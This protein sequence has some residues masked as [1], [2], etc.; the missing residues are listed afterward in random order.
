[1]SSPAADTAAAATA[2]A[3]KPSP[4]NVASAKNFEPS[5]PP[6]EGQGPTSSPSTDV[7]DRQ[8]HA[9][10]ISVESNASESDKRH[11]DGSH[12]AEDAAMSQQ[13]SPP[14]QASDPALRR[15]IVDLSDPV[16]AP[17]REIPPQKEQEQAKKKSYADLLKG[18]QDNAPPKRVKTVVN[19][20][21]PEYLSKLIDLASQED[22]NEEDVL[23]AISQATP[24]Q[25]KK[26]TT[27][28]WIETNGALYDKVY[29]NEKIIDAIFKE[30]QNAAWS[31]L[32]LEFVQLNKT[33]IG[34][35][36][37]SVTSRHVK[38]MLVGKTISIFGKEFT[39]PVPKVRSLGSSPSQELNDPMDK[40]F[41]M[42]IVGIRFNF[43]SAK[44]FRLLRRLKMKPIFQ[45]YRQHIPN[46]SCQSNVWRVYFLEAE[47]PKQ[48]VVNGHPADR[49][50]MDGVAYNV[51]V[52]NF[53]RSASRTSSA[54]PH[55]LDLDHAAALM[56]NPEKKLPEPEGQ[57]AED[58]GATQ[59]K[60]AKV[61]EEKQHEEPIVQGQSEESQTIEVIPPLTEQKSNEEPLPQGGDEES[62]EMEVTPLEI[63]PIVPPA[64]SQLSSNMEVDPKSTKRTTSQSVDEDGFVVPRSK[65][66][67][68]AAQA[69]PTFVSWASDNFFNA[70]ATIEATTTPVDSQH[71]TPTRVYIPAIKKISEESLKAR[72]AFVKR[73]HVADNKLCWHPDN[74]TMEELVQV[75]QAS[76]E[77]GAAFQHHNQ[78]NTTDIAG[79]ELDVVDYIRRCNV[80]GLWKVV[81]SHTQSMNV[82]LTKLATHTYS[83][84]LKVVRM[85]AWQRWM[86]A[87]QLPVVDSFTNGFKFTFQEHPKWTR[88]EEISRVLSFFEDAPKHP[89]FPT[90]QV[91][92]ALAAFELW[93]AV[94]APLVFRN[95]AWILYLTRQPVAWLPAKHGRML[96][97][98]T[99]WALLKSLFG[100][101]FA[102]ELNRVC[103]TEMSSRIWQLSVDAY[104]PTDNS[105]TA[106]VGNDNT[107]LQRRNNLLY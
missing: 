3:A 96:A 70:L 11:E 79:T 53:E 77:E 99:L 41:F 47:V 72:D 30:N 17:P 54:S 49:L 84:Y 63:E 29:T 25:V 2:D 58:Q 105:L 98:S 21:K 75:L 34:D 26:A 27:T 43:D 60:R 65:K 68:A 107:R 44:L 101:Y 13:A 14:D 24:I 6:E 12:H 87:T 97:P 35:I 36:V 7:E 46:V 16:G 45:A 78:A 15:V 39:I 20:P 10:E 67:V 31:Y 42:D 57:G 33:R 55:L 38:D 5:G 102:E 59:T 103:K 62:Q 92:D 40:F 86:S 100:Q 76:V 18:D 94:Q 51:F 89:A 104:Q 56:Q 74:L 37:V 93:I 106:F 80:D 22:A 61:N 83:D 66:R 90:D 82:V 8:L 71:E 85:H 19:R 48:L 23:E 50:K 52:K 88:L 9:N 73:Q 1:M 91:E 28:M 4:P 32:L 95:D 81:H 64:S 69:S